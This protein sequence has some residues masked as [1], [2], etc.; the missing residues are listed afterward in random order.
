MRRAIAPVAAAALLA[1][2]TRVHSQ[3][4]YRAAIFLVEASD[5]VS[6][7]LL[8]VQTGFLLESAPGLVTALHGVVGCAT[9]SARQPDRNNVTYRNLRPASVDIE[10]D[11]AILA[12]SGLPAAGGLSRHPTSLPGPGAVKVIGHPAGIAGLWEMELSL[13]S[14]TFMPLSMV[15]TQD[16]SPAI[17]KRGSPGIDVEVLGLNGNLQP[18]HSGAPILDSSGRVLGVASGGLGKG[19]L[20]IGWAIPLAKVQW[21]DASARRKEMDSLAWNEPALVFAYDDAAAPAVP[22]VVRSQGSACIGPAHFFDLDRGDSAPSQQQGDLFLEGVT[23]IERVLQPSPWSSAGIAAIGDRAFERVTLEALRRTEYQRLRIDASGDERNRLPSGTVIGVHTSEGRFAKMRIIDSRGD[24]VTFDWVTY[25]LPDE[26][27]SPLA[28]SI[29]PCGFKGT[30]LCGTGALAGDEIQSFSI[31][32]MAPDRVDLTVRYR[33]NPAHPQVYLGTT[34]LDNNGAS[35][36]GGFFP[37]AAPPSGVVS[38]KA[39]RVAGR[40]SRYLLVWLYE[41]YKSEAFACR[42]FDYRN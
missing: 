20:G 4:D 35:V 30:L 21:A 24:A 9:V 27:P 32:N 34:L 22:P 28:P 38:T 7:P 1:F 42:Q 29:E 31:Q 18:G 23:N 6:M 5:C 16:L 8:R 13:A 25:A 10:H 39:D 17:R 41:A 19:S 26:G 3:G 12:G 40:P 2:A 36:T 14:R 11:V 37:T 33:F 15:V